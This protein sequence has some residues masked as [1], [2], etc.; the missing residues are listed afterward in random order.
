MSSTLID[1]PAP[2]RSSEGLARLCLDHAADEQAQLEATLAF[3]QDVRAALLGKDHAALAGVLERHQATAR[4]A[5]AMADRRAA[6]QR[7]AADV[8]GVAPE[9]VTLDL[10]ADRLPA[11]AAGPVADARDRLRRMAAEVERLNTS[12]AT[13]LYHCLD[14]FRRFFDRLTG[15]PRDGRYGPEGKP[16]AATGGSLINARG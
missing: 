12:N 3:L 13:L 9:A 8:L 15:C 4:Q 11:D 1:L 2:P 16:A 10:L 7:E 14:F 6:F 5:A